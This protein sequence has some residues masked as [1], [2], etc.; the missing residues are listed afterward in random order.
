MCCN[1]PIDYKMLAKFF[2]DIVA[3]LDG[4]GGNSHIHI[5]NQSLSVIG[6]ELQFSKYPKKQIIIKKNKIILKINELKTKRKN[7]EA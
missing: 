4:E 1:K 6:Q 2:L 7:N 5:Y 3:W